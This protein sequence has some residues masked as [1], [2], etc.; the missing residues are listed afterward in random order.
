V[1]GAAAVEPERLLASWEGV[2]VYEARGGLLVVVNRRPDPAYGYTL[3]VEGEDGGE[4]LL[5]WL[6]PRR[7]SS[8]GTPALPAVLGVYNASIVL[9]AWRLDEL[10]SALGPGRYELVAYQEGS[11][12][13]SCSFTVSGGGVSFGGC[14]SGP[15]VGVSE[16]LV[17]G[18]GS[19]GSI[20]EALAF[21]VNETSTAAVARTVWGPGGPPGDPAEAAWSL[22][23][24]AERSLRYDHEKARLIS[25]GLPV[26]VQGPLE[27]LRRGAGVC[28]DYAVLLAA[29]LW[30]AG[31]PSMVLVFPG[32][33]HAAAATVVNDTMF[34]LDQRLPV[35]ELADYL[36]YTVP[37][38]DVF[39]V[40]LVADVAPEGST[41]MFYTLS[42]GEVEDS[43]PADRLEP[44]VLGLAAGLA[45]E[46]L[47]MEANPALATVAEWYSAYYALSTPELAEVQPRRAPLDALYSPVFRRQWA[48]MLSGYIEKLVTRYYWESVGVGS[49][50][51]IADH[52]ETHLLLRVKA[53]PVRFH[54]DVAVAGVELVV[55]IES[56][57]IGDPV[58]DVSLLLY[59][60]GAT[61]PCGG[62]APPGYRY[63][64][65]PSIAADTW[66]GGE[67]RARIAVDLGELR[68]LA[69]ACG[70]GDVRLGVWLGDSLVYLYPVR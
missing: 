60:R 2:E 55:S 17:A 28:S 25:S 14:T 39:G 22:L 1:V 48:E 29:G 64:D 27:T 50:W 43:Y 65:I 16:P 40:Y 8:E 4:R 3:V 52:N 38:E 53:V 41:V 34:V 18:L 32:A 10:A 23:S 59:R 54:I 9:G 19:Y 30:A 24:W 20:I 51:S 63:T 66:T 37:G 33:N 7:S 62:V 36:E 67:G 44:G 6:S 69:E 70:G 11:R 13:V 47:G 21:G 5:L 61:K 15:V 49:L 45:A 12:Y 57:A 56:P 31:L 68:R 58:R 46:R 35:V 26:G 42:R